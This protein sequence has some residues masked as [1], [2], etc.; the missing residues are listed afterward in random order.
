MIDLFISASSLGYSR[1][2]ENELFVRSTR[3]KFQPHIMLLYQLYHF[4]KDLE[5]TLI[6]LFF[7]FHFLLNK[8]TNY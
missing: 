4:K 5:L 6:S 8:K 3:N 2:L 1:W 7:Y